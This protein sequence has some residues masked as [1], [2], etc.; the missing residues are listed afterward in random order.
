M[1]STTQYIQ[2]LL[3]QIG[4]QNYDIQ[5]DILI[6]PSNENINICLEWIDGFY[7]P[8]LADFAASAQKSMPIQFSGDGELFDYNS[9]QQ[10]QN[11]GLPLFSSYL[12]VSSKDTLAATKYIQLLKIFPKYT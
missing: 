10:V 11:I 1:D 4:I 8:I 3:A 2:F 12:K 9:L 6:L 7:F 5:P